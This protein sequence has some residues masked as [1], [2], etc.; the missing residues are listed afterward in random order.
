MLLPPDVKDPAV[1]MLQ[2][3]EPAALLYC[4]SSSHSKHEL[5]FA[6]A[7]VPAG[8][9]VST[10]V[11][12]HAEPAGQIL[13]LVRLVASPPDVNEPELQTGQKVA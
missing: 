8:Q 13:Q 2:L 7:N 12:S 4:E 10:L 5:E 9:T 3:L 11:P 1:Q 6:G